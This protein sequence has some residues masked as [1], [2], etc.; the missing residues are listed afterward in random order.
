MVIKGTPRQITELHAG[1]MDICVAFDIGKAH[2]RIG[3][4]DIEIMADESH[5]ER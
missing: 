3:V 5:S 4:G 1:R 2:D